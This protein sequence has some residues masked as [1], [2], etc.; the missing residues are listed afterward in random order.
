MAGVN[1]TEPVAPPVAL[2]AAPPAARGAPAPTT[3]I[4]G[5]CVLAAMAAFLLTAYLTFRIGPPRPGRQ[6]ARGCAEHRPARI[7]LGRGD[8]RRRRVPLTKLL[9][10]LDGGIQGVGELDLARHRDL[11]VDGGRLGLELGGLLLDTRS[12]H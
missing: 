10:V 2:P 9:Y 6:L 8:L 5:W 12:D 1:E 4:F 7:L 3:R 11:R